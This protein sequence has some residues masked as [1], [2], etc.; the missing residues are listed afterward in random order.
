MR[1]CGESS[2]SDAFS[3]FGLFNDKTIIQSNIPFP[4][5]SLYVF[6]RGG[7]V[8]TDGELSKRFRQLRRR[9]VRLGR[10]YWCS[11]VDVFGLDSTSGRC[12]SRGSHF[13]GCGVFIVLRALGVLRLLV[14]RP[15]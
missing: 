13:A 1:Q 4:L 5:A 9:G 11:P 6:S 15:W 14:I 10:C 2:G 12:G 8:T 7:E 3:C